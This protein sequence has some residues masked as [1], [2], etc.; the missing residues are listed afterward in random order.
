M[1]KQDF[2]IANL[3]ARYLS[4]EISFEEKDELKSWRQKSPEHEALFQKIY[5][6]DNYKIHIENNLKFNIDSGWETVNKLIVKKNNRTRFLKILS[7]ASIIV[8]PLI[9]VS[10]STKYLSTDHLYLKEN[11]RLIAQPILPGSSKAILTL[12]D[13]QIINLDKHATDVLQKLDGTN[14]QIDSTTLNYQLAQKNSKVHAP[15]YNKVEIPRGGEY[16]L[17]LSDGTKVHLNSMSSLRFPV[18]FLKDKREVELEGEAYFEVSKT[19]QTF[20]VNTN[21]MQIEVLGTTFNISAYP[22]E[23][24]QTTLVNGSVKVKSN[25][26][27][28]LILKPSQQASINP[29]NSS[30]Q[31]KTVNTAFYTS[32]INGKINFKDQRLE[33]IM[34]TLSRWYDMDVVYTNERVKNIRFGCNVDRCDEIAPFV[35][36]LEKT[37]EVHV[38]IKGKTITFYN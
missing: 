17:V 7:Y 35:D 9:L 2:H 11:A 31:V 15:I 37:E 25:T 26:G 16:T 6:E 10:I 24:L 4:G 13:G 18:T 14:V 19:G 32:W 38:K 27:E 20:I 30:I 1:I 8:L 12:D 29:G 36:L 33:D 21:G 34:K 3:I 28:S 23:T 22:N 5:N